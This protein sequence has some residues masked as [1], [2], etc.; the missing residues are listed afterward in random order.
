MLMVLM[1]LRLLLLLMIEEMV[2]ADLSLKQ[3]LIK[4]RNVIWV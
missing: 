3:A 2:M 4:M 1:V